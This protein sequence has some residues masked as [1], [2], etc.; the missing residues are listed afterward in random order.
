MYTQLDIETHFDG[1][2]KIAYLNQPDTMNALTKP[3]L[4]DL[5]DFIKECSDDETVRCVAISG[6]GR[7]FCSGQNLDDA[8][9]QGNEHHDND[10]IRKIV[11]DYYNPL[12]TEITH[13][14]KPVVAL[15]N[16]PAVGAGAML[17]LIS[18]FVLAVDKSY[19]AQAFSNIGLIP[20]TGGTYFLPKLLGRQLANYLAFTGKRLS[21]EEAKSY[22][23]VAEVFTEE[24]F[25]PKSMEILE[26]MANMPT[27]AIKLTKKAFAASY[28]NT[29]KE[30]LELEGDLQQAAAETEDFKEGVQAFLQKR[31]PN[32]KGK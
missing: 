16:G 4:S 32:Y 1:K 23:L 3:S 11:V 2:L 22:G 20:D 25:A 5:K 14:K 17:A 30:Q 18:D 10:I 8:F 15:V 21:A 28:N 29:L 7:A 27:A 6:R 24:E 9:V 13:C 26:K 12:V 19:F 31:K